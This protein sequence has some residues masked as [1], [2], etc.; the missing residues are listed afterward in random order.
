MLK[1]TLLVLAILAGCTKAP[2]VDPPL[3]A[4]AGVGASLMPQGRQSSKAGRERAAL[5]AFDFGAVDLGLAPADVSQRPRAERELKRAREHQRR[6]EHLHALEGFAAAA[7]LASDWAPALAGLASGLVAMRLESEALQVFERTLILV[8]GDGDVLFGKGEVLL[9]MGRR[10][11][12]RAAFSA[13]LESQPQHAR[14]HGRLARLWFLAGDMPNA[15]SSAQL[16][17]DG[18]EDLPARLKALAGEGAPR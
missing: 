8:P 12:A 4:P 10:F 3:A 5:A 11:E 13:V 16:A 9:R 2:A 17:L 15:R 14:A 1:R 7:S 6:N 18:G